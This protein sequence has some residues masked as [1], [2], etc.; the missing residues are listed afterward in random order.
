MA[1]EQYTLT[2]LLWYVR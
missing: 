2:V 1:L